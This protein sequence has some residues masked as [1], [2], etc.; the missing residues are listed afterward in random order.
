LAYA[1]GT[2]AWPH[3]RTYFS[4]PLATFF[5][6]LAFYYVARR[7]SLTV[8]N[9]LAAGVAFSLALFTR[10]DSLVLLPALGL[11]IL[12]RLPLSPGY[13]DETA[14]PWTDPQLTGGMRSPSIREGYYI[15]RD[16]IAARTT[17]VGLLLIKVFGLPIDRKST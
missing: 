1:I 12:V 2:M 10:L 6:L 11:L 3:A 5:C 15:L 9:S 8:W 4:E 16:F 17:W 7:P 14:E 13:V